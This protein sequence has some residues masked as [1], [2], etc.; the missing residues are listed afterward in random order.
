MRV[1]K[2]TPLLL[3]LIADELFLAFKPPSLLLIEQNPGVLMHE[4]TI[5]TVMMHTG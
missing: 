1:S 2:F 5:R 4:K 3:R